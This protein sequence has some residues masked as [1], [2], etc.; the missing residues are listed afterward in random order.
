MMK[1]EIKK[2]TDY[3]LLQR[4]AWAT[5]GA[6]I[7]APLNKWYES[8]HSPIRSQIFWV[9]MEGIPSFVSV[10]LVRHH[11][12]VE[13]FVRSNREDRGGVKGADRL[14]PV[15][16]CM[17]INAQAL[18]NMARKRLCGKASKETREVM[19][20]IKWKLRECDSDLADLLVPECVYRGGRCYEFS[21]CG[22][23]KGVKDGL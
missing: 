19:N 7:K 14:T 12:G 10:H 13:H 18:I 16:H 17:L 15:T 6:E 22:Y 11:V 21:S 1:I 4:A 5:S 9:E 23:M 8:E 20:Q 3:A 2:L